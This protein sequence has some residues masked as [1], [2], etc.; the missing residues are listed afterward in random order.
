M[1]TTNKKQH[2]ETKEKLIRIILSK[3]HLLLMSLLLAYGGS[4]M[5]Y[6]LQNPENPLWLDLVRRLLGVYYQLMGAFLFIEWL[7]S[8]SYDAQESFLVES[9]IEK[10]YQH[11]C[12]L[13]EEVAMNEL[14]AWKR[15]D[16]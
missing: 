5:W 14:S 7:T 15:G 6:G 8:D 12:A 13:A 2:V 3:H 9:E 16:S 4:V 10:L 11:E 1:T